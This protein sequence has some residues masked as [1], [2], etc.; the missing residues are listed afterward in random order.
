MSEITDSQQ[1]V[2]QKKK[3]T[4]LSWVA[5]GLVAVGFIVA[6]TPGAGI[7]WLLLLPGFILSIIALAKKGGAKLVPLLALIASVV[8]WIISI[9]VTVAVASAVLGGAVQAANEAVTSTEAPLVAEE[10]TVGI[11]ETVTNGD[12]IAFT[13]NSVTCGIPS[14]ESFGSATAALGQFC[15]IKYTVVNGSNESLSMS[16]RDIEGVLGN[17]TFVAELTMGVGGFGADHSAFMEL[18]PGLT[19]DGETYIDIPAGK[20]LDSVQ[21][22]PGWFSSPVEVVVS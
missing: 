10:N 13:V 2:V 15:S 3:P 16:Y 7:A 17:S 5:A 1:I 20:A 11:G 18:N 19:I 14:F 8:G 21:F 9:I 4:T 6:V 22:A 12:N